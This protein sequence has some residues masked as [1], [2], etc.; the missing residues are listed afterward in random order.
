[1]NASNLWFV[2]K[3]KVNFNRT[4]RAQMS[5]SFNAV[6]KVKHKLETEDLCDV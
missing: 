1:M 5:K 6:S 3:L 4:S 2:I